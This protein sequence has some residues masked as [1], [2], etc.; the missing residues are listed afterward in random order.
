MEINNALVQPSPG[1]SAKLDPT[2][3]AVNGVGF[4]LPQ[5]GGTDAAASLADTFDTFLALLTTQL[6]NQNPLDPMESEQFTQQLVQFAGVEQS[7]NSNKKLDQLVQLQTSNQLNGAV[8][9]IGR[10]VEVVADQLMLDNGGAKITYGLD[11]KAAKTIISIVDTAG[12]TVRTLNG[13]TDAGRHEFAWDGRDTNG[14]ELPDG[15]YNFSV[16]AVDADETTVDTVT[17]SVGQVTGIEIVDGAVTLNI[18]E[19]GVPFDAIFAVRDNEPR[20]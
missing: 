11:G 18:G 13:E 9:Y 20:I 12:R 7:I 6:K 4:R 17:A 10:S 14:A 19:L 2:R 5:D 1:G 16:V 3:E 15:V 8:S